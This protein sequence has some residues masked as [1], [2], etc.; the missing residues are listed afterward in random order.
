MKIY[1]GSTQ[2]IKKPR[3]MTSIRNLD[4]GNGFYTTTSLEQASRW[5]VLKKN[6]T[7]N[8]DNAIVTIYNCDKKLF[9]NENYNIK[10][11]EHATEAWLDFVIEN[12]NGNQSHEFD[13][14]KGPVANDN[15]FSTITLYESGLLSKGETILRLKPHEL[16]DQISF[17]NRK[18]LMALEYVGFELIE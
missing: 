17:H 3:I 8:A 16:F 12:R 4:F 10:I 13:I 15:L 14:I 6:R 1:H 9:K 18:A 11:F 7:K 5:A 2:N